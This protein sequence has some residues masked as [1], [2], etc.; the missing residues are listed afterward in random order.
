MLEAM[1]AGADDFLVKPFDELEL[2]ARLLVASA[3]STCKTNW[4]PRAS[5]CVTPPL[6]TVSPDC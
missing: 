4:F 2:K 3:F 1:Q 5:P 6:T